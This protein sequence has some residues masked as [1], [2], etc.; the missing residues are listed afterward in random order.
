[1]LQKCETHTWKQE[2]ALAL[3]TPCRMNPLHVASCIQYFWTGHLYMHIQLCFWYPRLHRWPL[4][5]NN[6]VLLGMHPTH[7]LLQVLQGIISRGW[8]LMRNE[9][10]VERMRPREK[11]RERLPTEMLADPDGVNIFISLLI[12]QSSSR[13][14][15]LKPTPPLQL[16][17]SMELVW[18]D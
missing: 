14:L 5:W 15:A 1:M 16:L 6:A 17:I 13:A 11:E 18:P 8:C 4:I 10:G 2:C 7:A 12:W 3:N 9:R